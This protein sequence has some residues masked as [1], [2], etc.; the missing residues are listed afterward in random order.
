MCAH[1]VRTLLPFQ[2]FFFSHFFY[3]YSR[4][5]FTIDFQIVRDI[6]LFFSLSFC[7]L[8][9]HS[10]KRS[11]IAFLGKTKLLKKCFE[12][13][14][15]GVINLSQLVLLFR[16]KLLSWEVD[17]AH[18]A[19]FHF[20]RVRKITRVIRMPAPVKRTSAVFYQ[21]YYTLYMRTVKLL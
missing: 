8:I 2:T 6:V 16:W 5:L 14:T 11:K 18:H 20:S 4:L 15:I 9:L 17:G 3:F 19:R 1:R 21:H 12:I 13:A 10:R 7:L